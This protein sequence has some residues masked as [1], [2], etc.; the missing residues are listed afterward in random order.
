MWKPRWR[1]HGIALRWKF[2][3]IL[4]IALIG[5]ALLDWPPSAD[6]AIPNTSSFLLFLGLTVGA[7][8]WIAEK[9]H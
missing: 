2:T 8:G 9:L 6:P 5:L 1:Y 4:G 3:Q 7:A